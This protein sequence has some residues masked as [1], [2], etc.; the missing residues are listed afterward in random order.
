MDRDRPRERG[1][2]PPA[3]KTDRR[4]GTPMVRNEPQRRAR[5]YAMATPLL[6]REQGES[7]WR[8]ASTLNVS[9]SGV[10]FRADGPP[11]DMRRDVEFIL[12]LPVFGE[13]PGTQVRC[14]G[15]VVRLGPD[16]LAGGG[17]AVATTI[18]NYEFV[19]RLPV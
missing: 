13:A 16:E 2:R 15:R 1:R 5:R 9:R 4:T 10:L 19:G 12:A 3:K 18:A 8:G 7:E 14:T 6:F 17:C 11:P